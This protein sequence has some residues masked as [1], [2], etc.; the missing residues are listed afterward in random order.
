M[1]VSIQLSSNSGGKSFI[2]L[3]VWAYNNA[4]VGSPRS[5]F[6]HPQ[7]HLRSRERIVIIMLSQ[8]RNDFILLDAFPREEVGGIAWFNLH[9]SHAFDPMEWLLLT[10]FSADD[11]GEVTFSRCERGM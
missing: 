10:L 9:R 7:S 8:T 5:K 4:E 2:G 1:R 6:V 11:F 3:S